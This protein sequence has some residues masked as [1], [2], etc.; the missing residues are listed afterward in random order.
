MNR[1]EFVSRTAATLGA[2]SLLTGDGSAQSAPAEIGIGVIGVGSRGKQVMRNLLRIHGVKI[3]ALCDVY[4]PRFAEG[5]KIT[6]EQTPIFHDYREML[7]QPGIAAVLVA[8]PLY[9][10]SE[11]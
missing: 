11:H 6:S 8:T 5:R 7:Q 9:L 3:R 1:R 2:M 4:E 10:H